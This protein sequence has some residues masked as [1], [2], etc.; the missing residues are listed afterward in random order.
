MNVT[1]DLDMRAADGKIRRDLFLASGLM[2]FTEIALIRWLG[3]NVLYL[4]FF[5]NFILLAS[6]LGIGVGFLRATQDLG[7][8][9]WSVPL[10]FALLALVHLFPVDID[11]SAQEV[12]FLGSGKTRGLPIWVVLPFMFILTTAVMA[13]IGH[14]VGRLFAQLRP[15]T[16]YH[17]DI[18]GSVVGVIGFASLSY[19]QTPPLVWGLILVGVCLFLL[20]EQRGAVQLLAG[21]GILLIL[22]AQTFNPIYRWS[23]YYQIATLDLDEVISISVNQI[24]HQAMATT[25]YLREVGW[26]ATRTFELL[27]IE[28]PDDVLIVGAG[29]G[30]DVA[31]ALEAGARHIDAVEIDPGIYEQGR[32]L[33][34]N[35]PYD[36]TDRVSVHIDDGRA[37]VERSEKSYDFIL[38]ALTDSLTVVS[39]QSS[40]RLESYLFTEESVEATRDLLTDDGVL[41][42]YNLHSHQWVID[43]MGRTLQEVSGQRP[44]FRQE[45]GV[46]GVTLAIGNVED[47]C[48]GGTFRD[49][50][51]APQPATDDYP[52]LYIQERGIPSFYLVAIGAILVASLVAVRIGVPRISSIRPFADLF[53]MGTAFLLLETKAVVQFALWFGTTWV[54]NAIVFASILVSVLLAIEVVERFRVPS[55]PVLYTLLGLALLAAWLIPADLLLGLP[56]VARVVAAAAL[57]FTPVFLANVIFAERFKDVSSSTVA[58]GANLLG[59]MVGGLL[60]YA[61]LIVGYRGLT[62]VV[63]LLYA[64]AFL[65]LRRQQAVRLRAAP[66]S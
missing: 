23:P 45:P 28:G 17:M 63:G 36:E 41:A 2:L 32:R 26:V 15:L 58:F 3:E 61:S 43:R 6:F 64:T 20:R 31:L 18:L 10:L 35:R 57:T 25:D 27:E 33:H 19:L 14:G 55:F 65:L 66:A 4:S 13:T 51:T 30:N 9:R 44:C 59:A 37:F 11:R 48:D 29:T 53:F 40:L 5:T 1:L 16:A 42:F 8:F 60:E 52:F 39:G 54:V 34:P 24:P 50:S 62:I 56:I 47:V 46:R 12:L 38:F 22:G 49:F 21:V 7:W